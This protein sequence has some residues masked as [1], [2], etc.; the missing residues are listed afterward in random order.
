IRAV[1][2]RADAWRDAALRRAHRQLARGADL[3]DVLESLARGL[4]AK[5]MHGALSELR[6]ADP[7]HREQM[8]GM[9]QRLFLRGDSRSS[10]A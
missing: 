7:D 10:V 8:S 5:M 2:A 9:M 6:C 4:T 3:D 1:N